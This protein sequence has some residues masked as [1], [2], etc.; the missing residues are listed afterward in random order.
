MTIARRAKYKLA[1]CILNGFSK[2]VINNYALIKQNEIESET[3][4]INASLLNC[5]I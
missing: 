1:N 4:F 2:D 3:Q 5:I